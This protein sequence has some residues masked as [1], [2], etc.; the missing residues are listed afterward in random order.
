MLCPVGRGRD[1]AARAALPVG[2]GG[3]ASHALAAQGHGYLDAVT[4]TVAVR[5]TIEPEPEWIEP[6]A[7]AYQRFRSL[8]PA[9]R[10]LEDE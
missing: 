7:D 4:A 9:L 2:Y 10:P 5:D 8:Y 3:E 6:Y 1:R